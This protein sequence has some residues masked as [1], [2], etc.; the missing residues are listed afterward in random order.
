MLL[1]L[2]CTLGAALVAAAL[3]AP[4]EAVAQRSLDQVFLTKGAPARGDIP[5]NGMTRD[6]VTLE[7]TGN[8]REIEIKDIVRITFK[9]EP[10]EVNSARTSVLQKNYGQALTDLKKLDGQKIDREFIKQ[11]IEFYRALC[12]ARLAMGEGGDKAAAAEAMRR[13]A[14][15]AAQN[16]HFYEAAEVLGDLA[17]ASGKYADAAKFYGPIT[18]AGGNTPWPDYQMRGYNAQGRALIGEKK[19]DEG[20]EKFKAV[21]S[22]E[23]ATP[24]AL[25]QKNFAQIGRAICV[26]ETG[27]PQEAITTLQDLISKNDAQDTALFAR[28]YNALGRCYL[29]LNKPKDALLAL[30]HTDTLFYADGEA[31]A[32][33]LYHLSKLWP[34]VNKSDRGVAA[35]NT[36]R[37]RYAGSVW[38]TLE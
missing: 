17:M 21:L 36:L 25:K 15:S 14:T 10:A 18:S 11:D 33:A 3:V 5:D 27:N 2:V 26:A 7:T 32:E 19:F 23:L 6:K 1:R 38:A 37:E 22:M 35:R 13:F 29:K 34:A 16:Y 30:L 9:D 20:L 28:T 8:S 24:E 31:H 12:L 4:N